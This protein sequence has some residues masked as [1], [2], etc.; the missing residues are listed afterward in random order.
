M[1]NQRPSWE[2]L[3]IA[4]LVTAL[5]GIVVASLVFHLDGLERGQVVV[6]LLTALAWVDAWMYRTDRP[7][8]RFAG[9]GILSALAVHLVFQ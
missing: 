7:W 8:L 4:L 6:V 2:L 1:S 3:R 9:T 5:L